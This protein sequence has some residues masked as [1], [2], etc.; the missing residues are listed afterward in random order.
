MKNK[1][2]NIKLNK[3]SKIKGSGV[4]V[5]VLSAMVFSVYTMSTFSES[6]HFS[7]LIDKYEKNIKEYYEKNVDNIDEY[8]NQILIKNDEKE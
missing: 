1:I 8:Y 2:N 5:V 4:L 7:I 3:M 6:Q